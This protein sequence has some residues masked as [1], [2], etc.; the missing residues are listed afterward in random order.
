MRKPLGPDWRLGVLVAVAVVGVWWV[1]PRPALAETTTRYEWETG[2]TCPTGWTLD[3]NATY[4]G[5]KAC[6]I[7]TGAPKTVS[8]DFTAATPFVIKEYAILHGG[9]GTGDWRIDGGA[10]T[11]YSGAGTFTG[12]PALVFTTGT[13]TAGTHTLEIRGNNN[14]HYLDAADVVAEDPPPT[15]TTTTE[16]PTTTTTVPPTTTTTVPPTTTTTVPTTTTTAPGTSL[17]DDPNA[18]PVSSMLAIG[19]LVGG[20]VSGSVLTRLMRP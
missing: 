16:P 11:N 7:N 2:S 9:G 14:G 20:L 17:S 1:G 18:L 15:T 12:V 13:L 10:W 3:S 6:Y 5:G 19:G 8:K 4:S